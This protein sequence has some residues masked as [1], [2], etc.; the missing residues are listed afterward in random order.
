MEVAVWA[1]LGGALLLAEFAM[2]ELVVV[3]FGLGALVNAFLIALIPALRGNIPLQI[4]LWAATSGIALAFLR[5]YAAR[6]FRGD[7]PEIRPA[8]VGE[9][10]YVVEAISPEHPGRIRYRGTTWQARSVQET[11]PAGSTVTLLEKQNL[12]YLVTRENLLDSDQ[13]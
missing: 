7:G 10:A 5:R 9:T 12:T 11:I 3:F 6:W 4:T 13:S 1:V 8:G 2:P